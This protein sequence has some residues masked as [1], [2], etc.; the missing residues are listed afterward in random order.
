[1]PVAGNVMHSIEVWLDDQGKLHEGAIMH[2]S[3]SVCN[4]LNET[5]YMLDANLRNT[6][7]YMLLYGDN[8]TQLR[9]AFNGGEG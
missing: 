9:R 3:S 2:R 7:T 6:H 1:M 8:L 4:H 5:I